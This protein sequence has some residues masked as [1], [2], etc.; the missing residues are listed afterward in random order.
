M[1]PS[2]VKMIS[3]DPLF[4]HAKAQ[5]MLKL[6]LVDLWFCIGHATSLTKP[7]IVALYVVGTALD[8]FFR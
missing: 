3:G 5:S 6:V 1:S 4:A 2:L 8:W 7:S